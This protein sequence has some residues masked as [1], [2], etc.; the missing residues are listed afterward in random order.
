[1]KIDYVIKIGG[2]IL[3]DCT[4]ASVLLNLLYK[5]KNANYVIT[6]GSGY[7]GEMYKDFV[8]ERND[9]NIEFNNSVRDYS[10][11]QSINASVLSSINKNYIVC[12]NEEQINYVLKQGKIPIADARGFLDVYRKDLYQ[13]SDVR[14]A[15]ICNY[16]NCKNLIVITNVSGIYNLDPNVDSNAQKLNWVNAEDLKTM[17]RTAVDDGLAEKLIALN[18]NCCV[19]GIRN[20]I[21]NMG[22]IDRK[23]FA[24]GTIIKSNSQQE[25]VNEG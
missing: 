18:L 1:M 2:S 23:L 21:S 8:Y 14:A 22:K 4:E 19:V 6:V 10:N 25:E 5:N 9:L 16:L 12:E 15:N 20:L 13:K 11:I 7:I 17:G 3:Y 24:T